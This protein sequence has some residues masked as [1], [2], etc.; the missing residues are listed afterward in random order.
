MNIKKR[1]KAIEEA[2]KAI[3]DRAVIELTS[4]YYKAYHEGRHDYRDKIKKF[5]TINP[6]MKD[7]LTAMRKDPCEDCV[8][9]FSEFKLECIH[10]PH[11]KKKQDQLLAL[12][13]L[14][15]FI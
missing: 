5:L 9:S 1:N 11:C 13:I 8:H 14:K 6:E 10:S 2:S 7:I 3:S 15:H 12:D 4:I